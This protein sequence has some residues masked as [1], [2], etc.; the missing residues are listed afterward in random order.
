MS[1]R[2]SL[3]YLSWWQQQSK[4][5]KKKTTQYFATEHPSS[6]IVTLSIF[7]HWLNVSLTHTQNHTLT[8]QPWHNA[9]VILWTACKRGILCSLSHSHSLLH[10]KR[11]IA[12]M[13]SGIQSIFFLIS[14]CFNL[15]CLASSCC[16]QQFQWC[17]NAQIQR[18]L[19]T[20]EVI[21]T[22]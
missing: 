9:G 15:I 11:G 6:Y 13:T 1:K 7:L 20:Q 10:N 17:R 4:S 3:V 2:V 14:F 18:T 22:I 12:S 5:F 21:Y 8:Q 19:S 16:V